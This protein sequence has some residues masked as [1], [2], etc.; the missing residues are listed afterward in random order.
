MKRRS[1]SAR[2]GAN[3]TD[4]Q[5]AWLKGEDIMNSDNVMEALALL[6]DVFGTNTALFENHGASEKFFWRRPMDQPITR[7]E[8]RDHENDW[9]FSAEGDGDNFGG[10]SYFIFT[11]YTSEERQKLWDEAGQKK[12]YHWEPVL[13]R[14]IPR[15]A[16][17]DTAMVAFGD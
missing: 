11:Y 2:A 4:M 1:N 14:P 3:V 16:S 6:R 13:R 12:L 15:G 7:E 5:S 8:L 9:L 10:E 17:V